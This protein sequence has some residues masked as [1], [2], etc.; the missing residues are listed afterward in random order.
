MSLKITARM[1]LLAVGMIVWMAAPPAAAAS[2][3][4]NVCTQNP[5]PA[6]V[7]FCG[8]GICDAY[9]GET[10]LTCPADCAPKIS[11]PATATPTASPTATAQQTQ[12][13]TATVT[14]A[15]TSTLVSAAGCGF[16]AYASMT[17]TWQTTYASYAKSFIPSRPDHQEVYVCDVPP[18]GQ[19]CIPIYN[20]L[21]DVA[22]GKQ[23]QIGFVACT[24]AGQCA[25]LKGKLN[26]VGEALCADTTVAGTFTCSGGCALAP[27]APPAS[28]GSSLGD[29]LNQ[30]NVPVQTVVPIAC[31]LL[32]IAVGAVGFLI[33][34][35]RRSRQ[36][37]VPSE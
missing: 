22:G 7:G 18:S 8:D 1:T 35:S 32:L 37:E 5:Q 15:P 24:S 27:Q 30:L 23:D 4:T 9:A 3:T 11:L 25:L 10:A 17:N 2:Q 20:G 19:V 14:P 33:F 28:T 6:L 21:L 31:F 13:A 16:V 36:R 12:T 34:V 29:F 26:K